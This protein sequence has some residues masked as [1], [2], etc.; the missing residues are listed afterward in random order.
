MEP[1]GLN[2][3]GFYLTALDEESWLADRAY[4]W[5]VREATTGDSI[6]EVALSPDGGV[7]SRGAESAG[8]RTA[9]AAVTRFAAVL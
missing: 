8:L 7:T 1:I 5:A 9:V 4:R 3:G 6:G 2:V